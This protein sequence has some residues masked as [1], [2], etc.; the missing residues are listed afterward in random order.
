MHKTIGG[1]Y[2]LP[3]ESDQDLHFLVRWIELDGV[4]TVPC[5]LEFVFV[6]ISEQGAEGYS[7]SVKNFVSSSTTQGF[8]GGWVRQEI[9]DA[10]DCCRC[11][12]GF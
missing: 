3:L 5:L 6:F 10:L 9:I 7:V 8:M 11:L 12:L 2:S 1:S 4:G